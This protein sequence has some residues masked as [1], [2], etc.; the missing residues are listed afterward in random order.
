MNYLL[1]WLLLFCSP[2]VR[3]G[4]RVLLWGDSQVEG[5]NYVLPRLSEKDHVTFLAVWVNGST[6][7]QWTEPKTQ[8]WDITGKLREMEEFKP[9]VVLI[10]LGSNDSYTEPQEKTRERIYGV[11]NQASAFDKVR[12]VVWIGPPDLKRATAGLEIFSGLVISTAAT[13]YDSRAIEIK[14]EP[15]QLHAHPKGR[16]VW[17]R[18]IWQRLT[19]ELLF[20]KAFAPR[21]YVFGVD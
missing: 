20:P 5:L 14:M 7:R 19:Q 3:P 10:S 15:D 16:N 2:A 1:M 18:W 13:Y 12:E 11:L 9:T 4:D 17:G 21:G 6:V 8:G